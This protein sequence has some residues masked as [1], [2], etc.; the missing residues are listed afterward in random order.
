VHDKKA[1]WIWGVL[2]ELEKAGLITLADKGYQ[3][4][5][6]AK[7]PYRGKNKPEPQKKPTAPMRHSAHP[8]SARTR[9]SKPG[10]SS[11]SSAAGPGAPVSLPGQSTYCGSVGHN[12]VG[13]GSLATL[14]DLGGNPCGER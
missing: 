5:T 4:S 11:A 12:Q 9:S 3:G 10:G 7:I 1:E 8:A 6:W 14:C 2:A 13:M